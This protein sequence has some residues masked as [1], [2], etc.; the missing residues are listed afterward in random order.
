MSRFPRAVALLA[1]VAVCAGCASAA[2][3]TAGT[4]QHGNAA[5]GTVPL[6]LITS[7]GTGQASW[8]VLPMGAASGANEFWQLFLRQAGQSHWSLATPPDIATNGAIDL[9]GLSGDALVAGVHPSLYLDYAPVSSTRDA[10][11]K[12]ASASPAPGL[13]SVPAAL[14]ATPDGG[15]LLA[16]TRAG[17]VQASAGG[18]ARWTTLA[19]THTLAGT[20]AGHACGLARLTAVAFSPAGAP[21]TAGTCTRPG[22]AGIFAYQGG[23]WR[24]AGPSLPAALSSRSVSVLSLAAAGRHVVAV[25]QAGPGSSAG[26]LVAWMTGS[27]RW[28][29]SPVLAVGQQRVTALASGSGGSVAVALGGRTA[30]ALAGPGASWRRLPALPRGRAVIVAQPPSGGLE[31][32]AA[33]G[34]DL[35]VWRLRPDA[36]GWVRAQA[37]SV[38]IQYGSSG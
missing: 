1:A 2:G 11:R 3:Q 17:Q 33:T 37:I 35:S 6:P 32:L 23:S 22:T 16:L 18:S 36:S 24:P 10:G 30:A 4:G 27:G 15:R 26:L 5:L 14:A 20:A 38:P 25:L 13:A 9:A 8:A 12:W 31:A 21:L 19:S 29:V 28:A 34:G 7:A